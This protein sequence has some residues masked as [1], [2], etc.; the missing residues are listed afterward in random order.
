MG[1]FL[2]RKLVAKQK[3]L[4]QHADHIVVS[5]TIAHPNQVLPIVRQWLPCIRILSPLNLQQ[6][7]EAGLR[8]YLGDKS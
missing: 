2:R 8:Q 3:L 7:L 1:F 5:T 4:E 6:A